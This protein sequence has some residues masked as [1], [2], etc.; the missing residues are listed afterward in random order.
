MTTGPDSPRQRRKLAQR[1]AILDAALRIAEEDGWAAVTTRRVA[2]AVDYRQPVIY[3]HF[4]GRD[5]LIKAIAIAGFVALTAEINALAS[6][7]GPAALEQL[8]HRYIAF[9]A[10]QPRRYEA[11]FTL[12]STLPFASADTPA[13]LRASFAAIR[14]VVATVVPEDRADSATELLWACCHGIATLRLAGRIPADRVD[15]HLAR[16]AHLWS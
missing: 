16:V 8:C 15:E 13:E 10:E 2:A 9:G 7:T 3:Q 14:A 5:E 1:Q 11:M 4:T 12:P 6:A